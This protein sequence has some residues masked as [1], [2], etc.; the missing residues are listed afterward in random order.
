MN[1]IWYEGFTKVSFSETIR[2]TET[3]CEVIS[4]FPRELV[5]V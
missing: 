4:S 5:V 1:P 3:G 2:I